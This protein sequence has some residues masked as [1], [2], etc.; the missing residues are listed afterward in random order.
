MKKKLQ[1]F[2]THNFRLIVLIALFIVFSAA[3]SK[4]WRPT[5]WSNVSNIVLKQAPFSI[6][7]ALCM[8]LSIIVGGI[9]LSIGATVAL[10]G[11]TA[12]KVMLITGSPIAGIAVGLLIG[13][14]IGFCN[15][16]LI[17][18]VG[19]PIFIATYSMKWILQG[20][21]LIVA[22][23]QQV[24]GF[25]QSFIH[26]FT[27]TRYT[28][29]IIC[30]AV[31][32][33]V[34][35][36]LTK[37]N[38]GRH[39]YAIGCNQTAAAFS[40]IKVAKVKIL[41]YSLSG[42][43]MGLVALM[44]LGNLAAIDPVTGESFAINAVAAALVGGASLGGGKGKASNAVIGALIFLV[45]TNGLILVGIPSLWSDFVIG[46]VILISVGMERVLEKLTPAMED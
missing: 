6:L 45:L 29:I 36:L 43:V 15:G 22:N 44:F 21:A 14:L 46:L 32:A 2:V 38:F 26:I 3:T 41:T 33:V 19:L 27:G 20:L 17:A 34:A 42:L 37:T 28:L 31:C 24:Y 23:G 12:G 39:L 7:M 25:T 9:D 16:F 11:C 40:G 35:V 8:T 4:F 18:K 1:F 10:V 13:L 5:N 30:V